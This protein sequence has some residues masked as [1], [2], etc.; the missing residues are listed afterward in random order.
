MEDTDRDSLECEMTHTKWAA[1]LPI[2]S[3][4]LVTSKSRGDV[5]AVLS[6]LLDLSGKLTFEFDRQQVPI[7][8]DFAKPPDFF[9]EYSKV[10]FE[11]LR[12]MFLILR[13]TAESDH[14]AP[15]FYEPDGSISTEDTLE[16][17]IEAAK[18][19]GAAEFQ[20]ALFEIVFASNLARPGVLMP[21]GGAIL[22]NGAPDREIPRW[23]NPIDHAVTETADVKWPALKT[24][25][26][27][28]VWNWLA[29]VPNFKEGVATTD[30]G[31]AL[32]AFSYLF[33]D[34]IDGAHPFR[35]GL[36]AILGL[37]AIYGEGTEQ[38]SRLLVERTN[39]FL[40]RQL[41]HKRALKEMYSFRSRFVHGDQD[42]PYAHRQFDTSDL[43][44]RFYSQSIS[45]EA[46]AIRVLTATLQTMIEQ[47]RYELAFRIEVEP[48][49]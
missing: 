37:E 18:Q 36:W 20:R 33:D 3:A 48:P 17:R 30:L 26:F 38:I 46:L 7:V 42:F 16:M 34:S 6:E 4:M 47:R 5:K 28:D 14:S 10:P 43:S 22:I 44:D 39:A 15:H 31:R 29:G 27:M 32:A 9:A 11:G 8:F 19:L 49:P 35:H 2:R 25:P 41:T 21:E 1:Y 45:P 23:L 12:P 40:G 24:L 13:A